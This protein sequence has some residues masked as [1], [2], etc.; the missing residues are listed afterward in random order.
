MKKI[1]Q[2][3]KRNKKLIFEAFMYLYHPAYK[4]VEKLFRDQTY[5]KFRYLISNFRYPALNRKN[6]RY[7][8]GEGDGFFNDAATYPLSLENYIFKNE[9]KKAFKLFT[10]K[11]KSNVDLRG[12]IFINSSK[13]KRFYFWGEGQNYSNNLEIFFDKASIFINKFFSKKKD[14]KIY[15]KIYTKT[16]KKIIIEKVDQ[17][18]KMFLTIQKNYF[19]ESFQKFHINMIKNQLNLLLKYNS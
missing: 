7:K 10:Q 18:Q 3:A 11:I 8:K 12:N 4:Y 17:F 5:G 13:G 14:E 1:I 9:N 15:V 19:K 6:N 2:L 16:Q